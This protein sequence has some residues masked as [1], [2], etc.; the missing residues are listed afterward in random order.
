MKK[1][2]I[3]TDFSEASLNSI[4]YAIDLFR[5]ER[6]ELQ[7]VNVITP[8]AIDYSYGAVVD[9][10]A[11]E[12]MI[13]DSKKAFTKIISQLRKDLHTQSFKIDYE[14]VIGQVVY[15][16]KELSK[17]YNPDLLIMGNQGSNYDP[18]SKFFGSVS[19]AIVGDPSVPT[20]LVP[21]SYKQ[22]GPIRSIL[23]ATK[24]YKSDL[25]DLS[26]VQDMFKMFQP[27]IHLFNVV[28]KPN[29][30]FITSHDKLLDKMKKLSTDF[31]LVQH[32]V[33]G[34]NFIET[35]LSFLRHSAFDMV[36][37]NKKHSSFLQRLIKQSYS[38]KLSHKIDVP[39]LVMN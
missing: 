20:L 6:V 8:L 27:I 24:M 29:K 11:V 10:K 4:K 21:F 17:S 3:P 34:S 16:I 25:F 39:L 22:A 23:F 19:S 33:V 30:K 14:I 2:L 9:E 35:L 31:D 5:Y 26:R 32:E 15:K 13:Q 37:T 36:V 38:S 28:K 1:I 7:L 12:I 18:V